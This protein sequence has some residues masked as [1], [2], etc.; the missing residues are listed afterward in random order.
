MYVQL[1]VPSCAHVALL[2]AVPSFAVSRETVVHAAP[3]Q[4]SIVI[5]DALLLTLVPK[6]KVIPLIG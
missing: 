2:T 4:Y 5:L 6:S 1:I 3:F